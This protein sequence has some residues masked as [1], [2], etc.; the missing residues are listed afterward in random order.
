MVEIRGILN[1]V[2]KKRK[3]RREGDI[4]SW[5]QREAIEKL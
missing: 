1:E 2:E 5:I 3:I 4:L